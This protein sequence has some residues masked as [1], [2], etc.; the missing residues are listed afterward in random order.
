MSR[1]WCR[2]MSALFDYMK[3][4]DNY[5]MERKSNRTSGRRNNGYS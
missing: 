4:I 1:C 3:G 2:L 5:G